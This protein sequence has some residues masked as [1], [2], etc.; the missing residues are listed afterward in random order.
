MKNGS[1]FI[2]KQVFFI[3]RIKIEYTIGKTPRKILTASLY[4]ME[5]R[6]PVPLL[7][8]LLQRL[9]LQ[10]KQ[11]PSFPP[12]MHRAVY[13]FPSPRYPLWSCPEYQGV[14]IRRS[15]SQPSRFYRMECHR[16]L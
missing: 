11:C 1:Y 9:L 16:F 10:H 6:L 3:S 13:R 2:E 4:N 5:A 14:K 8:G 12:Y 15:T 7:N